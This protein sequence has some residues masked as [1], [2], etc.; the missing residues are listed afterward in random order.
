MTQPNAERAKDVNWFMRFIRQLRLS[1]GLFRDPLVPLWTKAIP[2]AALAYIV[3]PTDLV[4]DFVI[5]LG[6]M[7]DLGALL[8][9][10]KLF[11][12]LCPPTIVARHLAEMSSIKGTCRIVHDDAPK[13]ADVAGYLEEPASRA[14]HI[15]PNKTEETKRDSE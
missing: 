3:L 11:T 12:A 9:G 8:L 2:L 4:P 7:D 10:L 14:E 5:G 13:Q 6:Q 1:W 15:S